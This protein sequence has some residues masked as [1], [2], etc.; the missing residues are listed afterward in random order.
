MPILDA[1]PDTI[2]FRDKIYEPTLVEVPAKIDLA[3]YKAVGVP[4]LN[5][6]QE[7]AC[8]GFGLATVVNY[9][10]LRRKLPPD[11]APVSA[12]MIYEMA[13]RYDEW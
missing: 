8:T 9:L 11:L 7:G 6:G 3:T 12:R 10:L 5:Q 13:K 1:R 4:I 2:D